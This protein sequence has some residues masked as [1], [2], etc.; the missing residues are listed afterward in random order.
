MV[1]YGFIDP[2]QGI[3][4]L[5]KALKAAGLDKYIAAKQEALDAWAK[6][7]NVQ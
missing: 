2:A 4:D 6:E 3:A 1:T 7:N 5:E